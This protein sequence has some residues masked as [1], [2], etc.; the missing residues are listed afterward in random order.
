MGLNAQSPFSMA[1]W[2]NAVWNPGS[3][4]VR[5]MV[6]IYGPVTD[7]PLGAPVTAVQIGTSLGTGDL[8]F[9]TWG[10]ATLC[11]TASAVMNVYNNPRTLS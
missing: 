11:T 5:S 6:G 4:Q 9:W 3:G 10:G 7:T 2:I 1:V 8:A